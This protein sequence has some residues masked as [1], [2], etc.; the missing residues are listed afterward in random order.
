MICFAGNA[1]S[2]SRASGQIK[3]GAA[4]I[5]RNALREFATENTK[6]LQKMAE[7]AADAAITS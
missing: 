1:P 4:A 2:H 5:A 3:N 7:A 6:A